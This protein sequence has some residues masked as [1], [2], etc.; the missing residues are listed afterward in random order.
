MRFYT[1]VHVKFMKSSEMSFSWKNTHL[2]FIGRRL[3]KKANGRHSIANVTLQLAKINT[4]V[5]ENINKE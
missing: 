5:F 2:I 1:E 3:M 4:L